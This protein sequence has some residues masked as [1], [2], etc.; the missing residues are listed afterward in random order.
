MLSGIASYLFGSAAE[1]D[2]PGESDDVKLTTFPMEN[3]WLLVDHAGV[4]DAVSLFLLC[5]YFLQ[6]V[7][8]IRNIGRVCKYFFNI[9]L[10]EVV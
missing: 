8:V 10:V 2:L 1:D 3:E 4:F 9:A 7:F 5:F 6:T